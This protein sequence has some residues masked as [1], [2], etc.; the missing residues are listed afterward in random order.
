MI[1]GL[2]DVRISW[3]PQTLS[4]PAIAS[5]GPRGNVDDEDAVL[6]VQAPGAAECRFGREDVSYD[7]MSYPMNKNA[8]GKFVGRV[9]DLEQGAYTFYARCKDA[10]GAKN[11]VSAATTFTVAQ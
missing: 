7:Q 9:C 2:V 3:A 1:F 11:N 10:G 8:A 6:S 4:G 5:F